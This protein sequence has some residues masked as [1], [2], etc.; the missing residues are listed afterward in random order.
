MT[1][2]E[3]KVNVLAWSNDRNM[4]DKENGST[5]IVQ[6]FKLVEELGETIGSSLK[7][8]QADLE[9]GLGDMQVVITNVQELLDLY[10][11]EQ[12]T[13]DAL[14]T[15]IT[16]SLDIMIEFGKAA[17]AIKDRNVVKFDES[18]RNILDMLEE[19]AKYH[20]INFDSA[21]H[22]AY[23][24]IKDRKGKMVNRNF[25]KDADLQ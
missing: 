3:T 16:K 14:T 17:Q 10:K 4:F 15:K 21:F 6:F 20:N 7:N 13:E 23:E 25:V 12:V 18:I 5:P 22:K 8:K 11:F 19:F 24:V 9:D 1:R 2:I